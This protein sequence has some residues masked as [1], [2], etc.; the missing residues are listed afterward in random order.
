MHTDIDRLTVLLD[1]CCVIF[2]PVYRLWYLH[3][4]KLG[5]EFFFVGHCYPGLVQRSGRLCLWKRICQRES[6]GP[7]HTGNRNLSIQV[8]HD[9]ITFTFKA[10]IYIKRFKKFQKVSSSGIWTHN[11]DHHWIKGWMLI[12]IGHR[13]MCYL[14][15]LKLKFVSCTISHLKN[16]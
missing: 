2:R 11:A 14:A 13:A 7:L 16:H 8:F 12:Q 5:L 6:S 15:D 10:K 3:G 9:K 4:T 1:S